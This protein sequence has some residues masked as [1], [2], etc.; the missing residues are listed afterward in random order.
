MGRFP[1]LWCIS[2]LAMGFVSPIS[3]NARAT[4]EAP[5]PP[6]TRII[7]A[8]LLM[9]D[10]DF[11][12]VRGERGEIRIE[13]TPETTV[14]EEFTFGDRIKAVVLPNDKAISIER[15]GPNDP[16]GII[17]NTPQAAPPI[18]LEQEARSTQGQPPEN[19]LPSPTLEDTRRIIIADLLMIDGDFYVVRGERGEIRI[20]VT[21]ETKMTETF[22]F[23]DRIKAEVLPNDEAV[24]ITRADPDDQPGIYIKKSPSRAAQTTSSQTSDKQTQQAKKA[25]LANSQAP[26]PQVRTIVADLLMVDGDF[27]VVRGERGEIRIEITPDT[28]LTE[29]F[30]FGDRIKAKVLPNDKAISVERA[31]PNEPVGVFEP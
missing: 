19:V 28:K 21:P 14:S 2:M 30:K 6:P 17:V 22:K 5:V 15:A 31:K 26:R 10:G 23:G 11:Y 3:A 4:L 20:E 8:D 24:W 13:I 29:T 12:V 18:P 9:I 7:V 1:F 16:V 25:P 27:Y